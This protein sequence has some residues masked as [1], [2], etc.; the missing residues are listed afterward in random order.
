M[1]AAGANPIP[2]PRHPERDAERRLLHHGGPLSG[3]HNFGCWPAADYASAAEALARLV[4]DAACLGPGQRVL[5]VGA[6]LGEEGRVARRRYGVAD[7][8]CTDVGHPDLSVTGAFDAVL[9]VDAAY[10]FSPREDWLRGLVARLQPGGRLAFT[11]LTLAPASALTRR[12]RQA[13]LVPLLARAGIAGED[14]LDLQGA[15]ARLR[16]AGL[17]DVTA[18]RLDHAVLDGFIAFE[19]RQRQRLAADGVPAG[20]AWRRVRVTAQ[21]LQWLR[22][23]PGVGLGYAAFSGR[24]ARAGA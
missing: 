19:R 24:R 2:D 12:A 11:D 16:A 22:A 17:T 18:T 14:L 1:A 15:L 4:A 7:V 8:V 9:C 10:H 21:A 5:A 3:W 23:A 6:G 13:L 20:A